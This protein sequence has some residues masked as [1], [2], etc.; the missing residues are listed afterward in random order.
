[1]QDNYTSNIYLA[2]HG[3]ESEQNVR[4]ISRVTAPVM[5]WSPIIHG[6]RTASFSPQI[7]RFYGARPAFAHIGR[8]WGNIDV[9][10][11]SYDFN[12]DRPGTVPCLKAPGNSY[13][14]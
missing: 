5:L 8:T 14:S 12:D 9:T 2:G 3:S 10:F 7:V 1:M 11:K 4:A 6:N 13:I